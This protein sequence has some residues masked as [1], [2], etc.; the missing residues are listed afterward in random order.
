MWSNLRDWLVRGSIPD[1]DILAGDLVAPKYRYD[2]E[3]RLKL[4]S[5]EDIRNRNVPS[6]DSGDA[7]GLTFAMPIGHDA[8]QGE[9]GRAWEDLVERLKEQEREGLEGIQTG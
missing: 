3:G 9:G 7:L 8:G 1:D 6:P 2:S 5:K 4:E